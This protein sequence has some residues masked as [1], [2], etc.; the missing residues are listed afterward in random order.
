ML[1][2]TLKNKMGLLSHTAEK[3]QENRETTQG[4]ANKKSI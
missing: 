3:K 2:T 1:L 4:H